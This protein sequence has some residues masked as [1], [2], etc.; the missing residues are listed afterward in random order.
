MVTQEQI[1]NMLKTN[2]RAVARALVALAARQTADEQLSQRTKYHNQ[3]GFRPCHA[4]MGTSMANFFK[5]NGYLTEKQIAYWR[6]KQKDG[7]MRIEIYASQLLEIAKQ[8][9]MTAAN[10][11]SDNFNQTWIEYKNAYAREEA[12]QEQL[13]F[14]WKMN[15]R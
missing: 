4:R 3:Q 5:R 11:A 14:E 1:V 13:V 12:R 7:K 8:K 10:A 6:V 2:S 15:N 9:A